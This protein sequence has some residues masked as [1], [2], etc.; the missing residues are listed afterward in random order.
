[1]ERTSLES[2]IFDHVEDDSLRFSSKGE[3]NGHGKMN[4]VSWNKRYDTLKL[5]EERKRKESIKVNEGDSIPMENGA[6]RRRNST[7][8]ESK[9]AYKRANCTRTRIQRNTFPSEAE[10]YVFW[11]IA[12]LI[13]GG[14][15]VSSFDTSLLAVREEGDES[16]LGMKIGI[17]D[18]CRRN[19]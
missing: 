12:R 2:V 13:L 15:L 9:Y 7:I 17:I 5:Q 8:L 10:L 14:I 6:D 3:N 4:R 18:V 16:Q 11:N 1:M 19:R